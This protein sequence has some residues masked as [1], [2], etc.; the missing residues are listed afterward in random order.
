MDSGKLTILL[1]RAKEDIEKDRIIFEREG[2]KVIGLP[3]IEEAPLEFEVPEGKFDFVIF[4]S[5]KA[6]KYFSSRVSLTGKEK[7]L[8]VGE[9]TK[10]AV[11]SYGYRVWAVPAQY[12]AEELVK[13]LEGYSGRVL[14]PRSNIGREEVIQRLRQMGFEV[15][16][17]DVYQ[18]KLVDYPPQEFEEKVNVS[19]FLVFASPSAVR[20]FFANLQKLSNRPTLSNKKII[21]IGKTTK[22]EWKKFFDVDCEMP[23]KPGMHEVL[24]MVKRL[25]SFLQ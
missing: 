15:W 9:K 13:L 1:T 24:N 22:E 4:Q 12:Y 20:A 3:L 14:I 10:E 16:P 2:F 7:I 25:A 6:V 17:L 18:T 11:E 8:A 23:E 21:C 5:Q 19:N